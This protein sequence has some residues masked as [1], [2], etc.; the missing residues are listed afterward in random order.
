MIAKSEIEALL[1]SKAKVLGVESDI[2]L[3]KSFITIE[4]NWDPSVVRYEPTFKYLLSP[5]TYAQR[6]MISLETEKQ[7]QHFSYGLFQVMG[8][9]IRELGFN[10]NL[11]KTLDPEKNI[12]LGITYFM[13]RCK[14]YPD[15]KDQIAAYNAGSPRRSKS[16]EY[17]NQ[18][19]VNKVFAT[20]NAYLE[21]DK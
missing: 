18:G 12:E 16:G 11:T 1:E 21:Q 2:A 15:L 20:Y 4:S 6:N 9:V 13:K 7:L 17:T 10:D 5:I 3:L 8:C 19:Y 14:K